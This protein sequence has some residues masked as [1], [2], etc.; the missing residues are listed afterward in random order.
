MSPAREHLRRVGLLVD[1]HAR[2]FHRTFSR[3]FG[4]GCVR[5]RSLRSA[6]GAFAAAGVATSTLAG[7]AGSRASGSRTPR[8]APPAATLAAAR[9]RSPAA[10]A[11]G[12]VDRRGRGAA[13][14][15]GLATSAAAASTTPAAAGSLAR[16]P[17]LLARLLPRQWL[18]ARPEPGLARAEPSEQTRP[19]LGDDLVLDVVGVDAELVER[20]VQRLFDRSTC[21]LD[22]L[23]VFGVPLFDLSAS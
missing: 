19:G 8:A 17:S 15:A 10:G 3:R 21:G 13:A 20:R 6:A 23:H 14:R 4:R 16:P 18:D 9:R 22:P 2:L 12:R 1:R 11:L 5:T 7:R